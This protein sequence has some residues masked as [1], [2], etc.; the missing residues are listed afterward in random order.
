MGLGPPGAGDPWALL[1]FPTGVACMESSGC[2]S[3]FLA[4]WPWVC[5]ICPVSGGSPGIPRAGIRPLFRALPIVGLAQMRAQSRREIK[6]V[7]DEKL[8]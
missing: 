3:H 7:G 5:V 2:A 8:N 4:G 1:C 6:C